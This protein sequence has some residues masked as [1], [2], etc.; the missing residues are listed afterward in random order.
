MSVAGSRRTVA[1][2]VARFTSADATPGT[3]RSAD[4]TL[5]TH[6]AHV[7]PVMARSLLSPI[8][9]LPSAAP[10]WGARTARSGK[11]LTR[12]G[13]RIAGCRQ[14][15]SHD[16]VIRRAAHAHGLGAE[17]D[18]RG[19][20]AL[21]GLEGLLD[22]PGAAFAVDRRHGVRPLGDGVAH[23]DSFSTP[24]RRGWVRVYSIAPQLG[25]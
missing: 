11:A 10:R 23:S 12:S 9:A 21:D 8:A 24:P 17:V 18:G 4:S 15:L 25:H 6:D 16:F 7:M 14:H 19:L 2:S 5:T 22:R 1:R 3:D 13:R 20:D